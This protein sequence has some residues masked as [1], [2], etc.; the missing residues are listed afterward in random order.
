VNFLVDRHG[1]RTD[2]YSDEGSGVEERLGEALDTS[3]D[4]SRSIHDDDVIEQTAVDDFLKYSIPSACSDL[5][6]PSTNT[7]PLRADHRLQP[8]RRPLCPRR[9][10]QTGLH[11]HGQS[12]PSDGSL[13]GECRV[14][15]PHPH[16]SSRSAHLELVEGAHHD[17]MGGI[18]NLGTQP[19]ASKRQA[20][21]LGVV[22]AEDSLISS[23]DHCPLGGLEEGF[24]VFLLTDAIRAVNVQPGDGDRAIAE[25]RSA[26]VIPLKSTDL[27]FPTTAPPR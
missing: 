5:G 25:M 8:R 9:P 26:G 15:C 20:E 17:V 1:V 2:A 4:L 7:F 23:F 24:E 3:D 10:V 22:R 14:G 6:S 27:E 21:G 19:V 13:I 11:D 12:Y 18:R 16:A